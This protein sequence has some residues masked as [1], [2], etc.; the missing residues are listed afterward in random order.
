MPPGRPRLK[1][2]KARVGSG[3][4]PRRTRKASAKQSKP[5]AKRHAPAVHRLSH[6]QYRDLF[7]TMALGV[8]YQDRN[9]RIVAA[10]KAAQDILGLTADQMRGRTSAEP[11]WKTIREDGSPLPGDEQPVK[12]AF[13]TGK[14]VRDVLM[15]V[16]HPNDRAA[17]WILATSIPQFKSRG[18][19]PYQVCTTFDDI[20]ERREAERTLRLT[21]HAMDHSHDAIAWVG[22]DARFLYVNDATCKRLGYTR[23]ELLTMTVSDVDAHIEKSMA[24]DYWDQIRQHGTHTFQTEHRRKD[25][26][27]IPVEIVVSHLS[28][29]GQEYFVANAR[30]L[31]ERRR[32]EAERNRMFNLSIDMQCVAG[33][34]GFFKQLNPAWEKTLGWATQELLG[35]PWLDFVHPDDRLATMGAG[36][37]LAAG[38]EVRAFENRYLCKDGTWRWLAWNSYPLPDEQSIYAVARD[39]TRQKQAEEA[40]L[41]SEERFRRLFEGAREA[42]FWADPETRR[43]INCN[44]AAEELTGRKRD[45]LIGQDQSILHPA[46]EPNRYRDLFDVCARHPESQE[47][48]AEVITNTGQ[49]RRVRISTSTDTF[50]GRD[51]IQGIFRDVTDRLEAENALRLMTWRNQA[52]L[53]AVPDIII[54]V[55]ENRIYRWANR[56]G[57]EFFGED[58][59]GREAA[60]YFEGEQATYETVQPLFDGQED[61]IYAESW[62]RRKDGQ[63]RL[64]AWWCRVLKDGQGNVTGAISTARDITEQ[65]R[66]QEAL[67][68]SERQLRVVADHAP[69]SIAQCG[70]DQRY[71]FVNQTYAGLFGLQPADIVGRHPHELLGEGAYQQASPHME[72]ALAGQPVEYDIVL[73]QGPDGP[74]TLH[75]AY[76]PESDA[77]GQVVGF[78]AAI[79]D[80]TERRRIEEERARLTAIL[81]NSSDLVSTSTLD[82]HVS[83]LN[84]AGR[85][86]VGWDESEDVTK[87]TIPD[88]H[89]D[90]ATQVICNEGIPAALEKGIWEGETA[91][92]TRDGREIPVSQTIMAHRLADGTLQYISTIMRDI[93]ERKRAEIALTESERLL[94]ETGDMARVGGWDVDLETRKVRW[95]PA[96]KLIHEVSP[97]Y[98]PTVEEA[99]AFYS[100]TS[101]ATIQQAVDLAINEGRPYDLELELTSAKG[102]QLW[103]RS[104]GKPVM[105]DGRCVRLSG[106][107]Q[108]ITERKQ[109]TLK[110]ERAQALLTA[111]I[112][113]SPSGIVIADAPDGHITMANPAAIGIPGE[114]CIALTGIEIGGHTTAWQIYCPDGVTPYP[115]VKLPLS[116]AIL[117]GAVSRDIEM[118]IRREDGED[119][120]VSANAGPIRDHSGMI[121]AAIVV[122]HDITDRKR[123]EDALRQ[124]RERLSAL[125]TAITDAVYV[126]EIDADGGPGRIIE[127]NDVACRM[128]GYR[129]EEMLT[130]TIRDIDAPESSL[131]ARAVI[132][133]LK[134]GHDVTFEQT[135][136]TKEGRRIPVEIHACIFDMKGTPVL[137]STVRD[138]TDRKKTEQ[139]RERLVRELESKNTELESLVYVASHDLRSPLVNILGFSSEMERASLFL[140]ALLRQ[141]EVPAHVREHAEPYLKD[142]IPT[143]VGFIKASG[144]KMDALIE[145]LL[146]LSRTGR[147]ALNLKHL[148]MNTMIEN[149]VASMTYQIQQASA[150]I[151]IQP[152]PPCRGDEDQIGQAFSNILDNALKYRS[153]DRPLEIRISGSIEGDRAVYCVEDNGLGIAAEHEAKIWE[154]FHRLHPTGS[155][156]GEG[157]GLTLVRRIVDRHGGRTWV[158]S[159]PGVGSR[160]CVALP[161]TER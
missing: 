103:V 114:T 133:R 155:V 18:K 45:E 102:R 15:G 149:T 77:S 58:V 39:I 117:E 27:L 147:A 42:I 28:H 82:R 21:R 8:V 30:N 126:H 41:E 150:K 154:L 138:I 75:A 136:V 49:I 73:P 85:R 91:L 83:Y 4:S 107:F 1:K 90:W 54:E 119:R 44:R 69:V 61:V 9:G 3:K 64:L 13:R 20:T 16:F 22:P 84:A 62:Q 87:H 95:T 140:S 46:D 50:E 81:E 112:Q 99:M 161:S 34:D 124:S 148:D 59:I 151:D 57:I 48:D 105:K 156:P 152:L 86:M 130:L 159:E 131:D 121:V 137:L 60:Y 108:D 2:P 145:G 51:I 96:V 67:R 32:I 70:Q 71:R 122:F 24:P 7:E 132:E 143:A 97:E 80:I 68:E 144:Q 26:R 65:K 52:I 72:A 160:F 100:G 53:A 94:R 116:R 110:L 66:A 118:I 88:L 127:A 63:K 101:R 37:A 11:R 40:I 134:A 123:A 29:E 142:H 12:V 55:D 120:W 79:T 129:R 17:R 23:E 5:H 92:L 153:P 38:N 74:R 31:S 25:G 14:P 98:E 135:H 10:N 139:E 6:K 141:P 33:F 47:V 43:L 125:F 157:L 56:A 146:R 36:E 19:R 35:K 78:V 111:A 128:L 113:Q 93:T 158:E 89:P 106:T 76:S 104:A 115:S 109:A